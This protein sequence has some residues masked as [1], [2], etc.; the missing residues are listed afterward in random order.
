MPLHTAMELLHVDLTECILKVFYAVYNELGAGFLEQV[1]QTAMVIALIAEGLEVVEHTG[2]P[3]H[4]RG[5]IIGEFFPDLSINRKV[6][7]ELKSKRAVTLEDEAQGLNYLRVSDFEVLL[8][9]N[10]GPKPEVVRRILSNTRKALRG[11]PDAI[12]DLRIRNR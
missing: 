11:T 10:F 6:L 12:R 2:F 7:V 9:L 4:F 5:E 1:V 8:I 3:V